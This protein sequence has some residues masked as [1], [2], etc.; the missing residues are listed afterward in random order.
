[1]NSF[2]LSQAGKL[3]FPAL[4]VLSLIELYRGHNLPGGG[5]IGGLMASIAFI[6]LGLGVSMQEAARR[7]R[8][9]PVTLLYVGL[10][11]AVLSGIPGFFVGKAF[12]DGLWLPEFHLPLLGVVHLGT[13][14]LFDAG[15]YLAVIGFSLETVFSLAVLAEPDEEEE[16]S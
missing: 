5:F 7:L 3:L 13:P 8:V 16:P 4:L 12:M 6:L 14:L 2:I 9:R 10:G 1:M 15:V 11:I